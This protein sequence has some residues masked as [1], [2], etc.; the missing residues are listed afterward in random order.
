MIWLWSTVF[1]F[2]EFVSNLFDAVCEFDP[3]SMFSDDTRY[4]SVLSDLSGTR[5]FPTPRD[6]R[7]TTPVADLRK[8]S[9]MPRRVSQCWHRQPIDMKLVLKFQR[10]KETW[11]DMKW[12]EMTWNDM[13]WH[14]HVLQVH[15]QKRTILFQLFS[16]KLLISTSL[17][18]FNRSAQLCHSTGFLQRLDG[19]GCPG[20]IHRKTQAKRTRST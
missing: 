5:S 10:L 18:S 12:H 2:S 9:L 14:E 11:N 4:L 3:T 19:R 13:K 6:G 7:T 17:V 8:A 1:L 20:S 16:T 15:F